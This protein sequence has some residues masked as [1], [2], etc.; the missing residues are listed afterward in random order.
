MFN[1][2]YSRKVSL[3]TSYHCLYLSFSHCYVTKGIKFWSRPSGAQCTIL[4]H[5]SVILFLF[6]IHSVLIIGSWICFILWSSK[7][8]FLFFPKI[9]PSLFSYFWGSLLHWLIF[10]TLLE[11]WNFHYVS[12]SVQFSDFLQRSH[13]CKCDFHSYSI[14]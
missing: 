12:T 6:Q 10:Y 9:C 3:F 4:F 1:L 2:L 13:S 8:I 11:I 14:I 5:S 7:F